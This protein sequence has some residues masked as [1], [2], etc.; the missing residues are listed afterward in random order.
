MIASFWQLPKR[1]NH[2]PQKVLDKIADE[3]ARKI[4]DE[5]KL[6]ETRKG[7]AS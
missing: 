6:E 5:I 4:E 1:C 2:L 7:L 3:E